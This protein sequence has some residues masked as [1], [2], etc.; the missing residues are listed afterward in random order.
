[1]YLS[2]FLLNVQRRGPVDTGLVLA[3]LARVSFVV[4]D[5][6]SRASER[7]PLRG[8]IVGVLVLC[9][10]GMLLLRGLGPESS[11][12]R[13]AGGLGVIGAGIGFV[14]PLATF[15]HLGVLPPD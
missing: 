4:S 3:P 2:L 1:V 7:L 9:G 15:A 6:A 11:A 13:M 5:L 8:T 14:N 12:L 10:A